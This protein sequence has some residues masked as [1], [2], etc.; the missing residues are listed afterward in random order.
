MYSGA[1]P[2]FYTGMQALVEWLPAVPAP[3]LE[4]EFPLALFDGLSRAFLL[5]DLIPPMV[6]AHALPAIRENP[7]T[8]LLT[9]LVRP[10]SF[11]SVEVTSLCPRRLSEEVGDDDP[12]IGFQGELFPVYVPEGTRH[13]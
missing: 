2:A 6:T 4:L 7:W 1:V 11:F 8:L 12:G 9:S 3:T 5:C 10:S 13:V